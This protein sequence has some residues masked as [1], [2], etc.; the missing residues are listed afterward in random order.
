[1]EHQL[2][3]PKLKLYIKIKKC[4]IIKSIIYKHCQINIQIIYQYFFIVSLPEYFTIFS[5]YLSFVFNSSQTLPIP[6]CQKY[7]YTYVITYV[8]NRLLRPCS[9]VWV[10]IK[11]WFPCTSKCTILFFGNQLDINHNKKMQMFMFIHSLTGRHNSH[12]K[13]QVNPRKPSA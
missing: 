1:M 13:Y 7:F 10:C 9:Q 2:E 5:E 4:L 12:Q 3:G 8:I 11:N 6:C